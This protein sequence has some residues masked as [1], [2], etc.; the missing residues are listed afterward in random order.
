MVPLARKFR[1]L[2][3]RG[4]RAGELRSLDSGHTAISLVALAVIY[5]TA[6]PVVHVV[7]G[8]DP[9]DKV[10]LARRKEEVLKFVRHALFLYPEAAVI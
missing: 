10:N 1:E 8:V 9:Y 7:S 3:E 6:A 4:V 2:I 5:F